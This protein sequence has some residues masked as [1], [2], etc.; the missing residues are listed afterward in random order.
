MPVAYRTVRRHELKAG[1]HYLTVQLL[2]SGW[3]A[4]EM[5]QNGEEIPGEVFPEPWQTG[6]GRYRDRFEAEAEALRWSESDEIP[7]LEGQITGDHS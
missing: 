6:L 4:V 5:W 7:V 1:D 3:A 2:G